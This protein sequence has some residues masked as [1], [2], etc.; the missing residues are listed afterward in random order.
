MSKLIFEAKRQPQAPV[1]L[2][3]LSP[4]NLL[5]KKIAEIAKF[6]VW[7]GNR[8]AKLGTL[9][10]IKE[11][12]SDASQESS[13][14]VAGDLS[15]ARRIGYK[16]AAGTIRIRGHG[17]LYIGESM[18]GGSIVI[19][20]DA[21]SWLGSNMKGGAIDVIGNAGDLVGAASRGA[22]KGMTGG[23]IVIRGNAGSEI[24]EWMLS[25]TI[26][27][28]GSTEMFPGV[29]MLGGAIHIAG[30]CPGRAGAH[31][32]GGKIVVSGNLPA[33]LPSF[34]FEEIRGQT[35]IEKDSLDGPFYVFSG[36][37]NEDGNGRI[38]ISV[39]RNPQLKW[40]EKFLET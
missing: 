21:G 14:E 20:G 19:E 5:D 9:F 17:G 12:R 15:K 36:D 10:R 6:E 8:R 29:H 16:M 26:R 28:S 35:K 2:E 4:Q 31:M 13:I 27:I 7:E 39:P 30:D 33:V 23:S 37:N 34:S 32:K 24:G 18:S 25:G 3:P 38:F 1:H 40:C 11:D 22:T